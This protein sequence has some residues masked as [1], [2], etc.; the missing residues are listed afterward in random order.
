MSKRWVAQPRVTLTRLSAEGKRREICPAV[1]LEKLSRIA[2]H[3]GRV[4][5][6]LGCDL[7]V[8]NMDES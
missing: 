8:N 3:G 2:R 7:T 6:T 4:M 5:L 1:V